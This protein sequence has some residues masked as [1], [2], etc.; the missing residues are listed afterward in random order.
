[1]GPGS[2]DQATDRQG[3]LTCRS[4]QLTK[5][6]GKEASG[7]TKTHKRVSGKSRIA[8]LWNAAIQIATDQFLQNHGLTAAAT[9]D[10]WGATSTPRGVI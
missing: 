2:M 4:R 10:C 8:Q 3:C 5:I 9:A 6:G 7:V 1:M